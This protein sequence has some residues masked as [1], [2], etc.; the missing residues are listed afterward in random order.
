MER[1]DKDTILD[2]TKTYF[3]NN[4]LCNATT[5]DFT[6]I[7]EELEMI[8]TNNIYMMYPS[9]FSI[10]TWMTNKRIFLFYPPYQNYILYFIN[11]LFYYFSD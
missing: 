10:L 9:V 6:R 4:F 5:N 7:I 2:S 3:D 1:I 8:P 11:P